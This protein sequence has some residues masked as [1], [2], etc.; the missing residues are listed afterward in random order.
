MSQ[1]LLSVTSA[2]A[3]HVLWD[4]DFGTRRPR[5]LLP[6]GEFPIR[7]ALG[8]RTDAAYGPQKE[9]DRTGWERD[10]FDVDAGGLGNSGTSHEVNLLGR[11]VDCNG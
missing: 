7:M 4:G 3:Q 9:S 10:L 2:A 1:N 8:T 6:V 11:S 5:I